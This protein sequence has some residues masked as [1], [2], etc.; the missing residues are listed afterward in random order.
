MHILSNAAHTHAHAHRC[1]ADSTSRQLDASHAV[2]LA[3]LAEVVVRHLEKDV[4]LQLRTRKNDELTRAYSQVDAC[5]T[6]G[7]VNSTTRL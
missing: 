4:A 5:L 1:F 2:I 6:R 7:V 3:N